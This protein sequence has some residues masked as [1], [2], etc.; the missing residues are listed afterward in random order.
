[1]KLSDIKR[2]DILV[3][4]YNDDVT[5]NDFE[6]NYIVFIANGSKI[7]ISSKNEVYTCYIIPAIASIDLT[8]ELTINKSQR[9]NENVGFTI[10][11]KTPYK[12]TKLRKPTISDVLDIVNR[13]NKYGYKYNKKTKK[14]IKL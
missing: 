9:T 14:L 13:L 11:H 12:T 8:N 4:Q 6:R 3:A 2:G 5:V 7:R 10:Y 1:M